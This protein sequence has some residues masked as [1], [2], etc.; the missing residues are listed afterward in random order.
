M[1]DSQPKS[2][3]WA[4]L[5]WPALGI[6]LSPV[7]V[8]WWTYAWAPDTRLLPL[9]LPLGLILWARGIEWRSPRHPR[10]ALGTSLI[11]IGLGLEIFGILAQTWTV[12]RLAAPIGAIGMAM[13]LGNPSPRLLTL[14]FFA[15]PIPTFIMQSTTPALESFYAAVVSQGLAEALGLAV[16]SSGPLLIAESRSLELT[17]PDA[18]WQTAFLLMAGLWTLALVRRWSISRIILLGV[19][20]LLT[21]PPLQI[22]AVG[23]A[24][25]L[26]TSGLP[27][28][29]TAWLR[30][31][32]Y[33][34]LF[35]LALF[36]F[37]GWRPARKTPASPL[38]TPAP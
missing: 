20:L 3:S 30:W 38:H 26:L 33:L 35:V 18:G 5:E 36:F 31:G 23:V 21:V 27:D 8:E 25:L 15:V 1:T 22:G 11:L 32:F 29:G 28:W 17:A 10:S 6:A 2:V 4:W 16:T 24:G 19:A 9:V 12:A 7:L 34:T 13:R 14:L 37:K